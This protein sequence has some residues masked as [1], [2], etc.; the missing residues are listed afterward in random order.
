MRLIVTR[1][2]PDATRTAHALIAL[3]HAAIL[4]PML[5]VAP[6]PDARVS[7]GPIQAVLATSSN[8]VRALAAH[9]ARARL[10]P[11]PFFAVGDRTALE[12]RRA[13]FRGARSAGGALADLAAL[14][15]AELR[16]G[17][18][19][20]LY[21]AGDVRSGDLAGDLGAVGFEVATVVVYRAVARLRL[22]GVATD[23][24]R[25]GEADGILVYS[26]RSAAALVLALRA[27]G[28]SP[29]AERVVCYALSE[30][31]AEPLAGIAGA[32]VRVAAHADQISLFALLDRASAETPSA[33]DAAVPPG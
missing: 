9:P 27:A 17:D 7:D 8:A 4:S 22:S 5:E 26:R 31:A 14:V 18:G 13:G 6:D 20:L 32:P 19:P 15:R 21:A 29:L 11:L 12:A 3:G 16:P 28:L 1:P 10:E 2:E 23:A 30:A 24:L 25:A 33:A